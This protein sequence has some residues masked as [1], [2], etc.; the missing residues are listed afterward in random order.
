MYIQNAPDD[1][2]RGKLDANSLAVMDYQMKEVDRYRTAMRKMAADL[3]HVREDCKRLDEANSKLRRELGQ[4][5][6]YRLMVS[7]KDLD[8]VTHS[9][10]VQKFVST[11]TGES[12]RKLSE[13]N[14]RLQAEV[15]QYKEQLK[16]AEAKLKKPRSPGEQRVVGA[17]NGPMSDMER[18]E[19]FEKLEKAEGRIVALEKQLADNVRK[20]AKDKA[21]LQMKL[22]ESQVAQRTGYKNSS[23]SVDILDWHNGPK[24]NSPSRHLG[25]R[26][27]SPK[28]DPLERR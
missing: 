25:P 15:L 9:E 14:I 6:R 3:L 27:P 11:E 19:L 23:T 5:T 2:V 8:N 13:E 1:R 16:A 4:H 12:Y 22:N 21:D 20:W 24:P 7:S 26:R 28:L 18:L 10:L 17:S